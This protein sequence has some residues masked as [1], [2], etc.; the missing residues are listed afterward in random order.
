M[1]FEDLTLDELRALFRG[2]S[3]QKVSLLAS[4]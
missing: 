2:A 4:Y 3:W 1:E